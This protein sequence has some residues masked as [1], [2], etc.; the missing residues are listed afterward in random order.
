MLTPDHV[1]GSP[2]A[3]PV[4]PREYRG[5][6]ATFTG[7]PYK[8]HP[9]PGRL[10]TPGRRLPRIRFP[11]A[12]GWISR[13]RTSAIRWVDPW[14]GGLPPQIPSGQPTRSVVDPSNHGGRL[15][16]TAHRSGT[17]GS[18]E[19]PSQVGEDHLPESGAKSSPNRV[20]TAGGCGSCTSRRRTSLRGWRP[21]SGWP[22]RGMLRR[23]RS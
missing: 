11:G 4:L 12:V 23:L 2:I 10:P 5:R 18:G 13:R 22:W 15:A 14:H 9:L 1:T 3:L 19:A 16:L 7:D 6:T 21:S 17:C 8:R 20:G